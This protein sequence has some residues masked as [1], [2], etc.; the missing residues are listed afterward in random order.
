MSRLLT[1]FS[2]DTMTY[3]RAFWLLVP[4]A[5]LLLVELA[6]RPG[7]AVTFSTGG[8]AAGLRR[9]FSRLVLALPPLLRA[10]GF[11]LLVVALAGPMTGHQLS[12]DRAGVIDIMLCMDV[13]GS[14]RQ[15]DFMMDGR[16]R[17]RM[18][19]AKQA[20]TKFIDSRR[21]ARGS[22][23]GMDRVGLVCFSGI[24]WTQCP[25]T[26][27]YDVLEREVQNAEVAP[28]SKQGTA[29]GSA[30]GLALR[31]LSQTE[32]KSK[33]V[34]LLSDGR[35]NRGELDPLSA[36][37]IAKEMGIRVYTIGAGSPEEQVLNGG[38]FPVRSEAI[39]EKMLRE[40]AEGTGGR[41]YLAT[42]TEALMG[43]Y[44]EIGALE[45]TEIDLGDYYEYHE[46]FLPW[47]LAGAALVLAS[48]FTRRTW[49]DPLP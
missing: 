35:N 5:L 49:L 18:H 37:Q 8:R 9:S 39:D 45:T 41:Y 3:P 11:A 16:P 29:I 26:L 24:A 10:A 48:L 6:A 20:V 36:A 21:E 28:D 33:V 47:M 32:A 1:T 42:N 7:G 23:Y 13:S 44:D 31:R 38:F 25:L 12:R 15:A 4:V 30:L 43:A 19:V 27:D 2:F 46:G 17:D 40:V 22:R 14:M 34:I